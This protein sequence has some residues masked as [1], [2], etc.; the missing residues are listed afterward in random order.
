MTRS[1]ETRLA[2]LEAAGNVEEVPPLVMVFHDWDHTI[3]WNCPPDLHTN[4]A[5]LTGATI[6]TNPP[7]ALT[8][9]EWRDYL[10]LH[11]ADRAAYDGPRVIEMLL[12][13]MKPGDI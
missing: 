2:A 8:P 9:G 10:A 3:P 5:Y 13:G 4:D 11:G 12:G 6:C 7:Q 1:L